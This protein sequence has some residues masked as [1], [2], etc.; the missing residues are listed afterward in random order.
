MPR[1]KQNGKP[2]GNPTVDQISKWL[3]LFI[4]PGQVTE[5]RALEVVSGKYKRTVSGYFDYEH[6]GTMAS[7]VLRLTGQSKGVYFVFNPIDSDCLSR[8]TNR[9][10][11][12]NKDEQ[13]SDNDVLQR[14]AILIDADPERKANISATDVEKKLAWETMKAIGQHLN[15]V[16]IN[17][18]VIADS[19][20]GYH[21][22]LW[23]NLPKEDAGM[24]K[25]FLHCLADQFGTDAV[26]I[27]TSVY[28]PARIT[29]LYGTMARK[30]DHSDERPHRWAYVLDDLGDQR[31]KAEAFA[32]YL[33]SKGWTLHD[34]EWKKTTDDP[35]VF[36]ATAKTNGRD[37]VSAARKYVSKL[38]DATSG[39][40]GHD[41]TWDVVHQLWQRFVPQGLSEPDAWDI[42]NEYNNTR[43]HPPWS[44]A[45]LAHKVEGAK[46]ARVRN[47]GKDF[48]P[49][50]DRKNVKGKGKKKKPQSIPQEGDGPLGYDIIKDWFETNFQPLHRTGT[51][52]FSA[53]LGRE[54]KATEATYA[55][56]IDLAKKLIE[57]AV[58]AKREGVTWNEATKFFSTWA[59]PAL[60]DLLAVLPEEECAD[61]VDEMAE[62]DFRDLVSM[63]LHTI[64]S[65][66]HKYQDGDQRTETQQRS[67]IEWAALFAKKGAFK[68]VR[69][70]EIWCKKDEDGSKQ[71]AIRHELFGQLRRADLRKIRRKKFAALCSRYGVGQ[72]DKINNSIRAIILTSEYLRDVCGVV[73]HEKPRA[74]A[75]EKKR[76]N[77]TFDANPTDGGT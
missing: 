33:E 72:S 49:E 21:R 74:H 30:G 11:F 41:A 16:G 10:D 15:E 34:E 3:K 37:I 24:V 28:N 50:P 38:P 47:L 48:V 43:C 9:T 68:K 46:N 73:A 56:S 19:G 64:I 23:V 7:E 71:I 75:S 25:A 14:S 76:H 45:E 39:N 61:E 29:K 55:P 17:G 59:K 35:S 65:L 5:L 12:A 42:L 40:H 62:E 52:F 13:T 54:V 27:D 18:G 26:S 51:G 77:A 1:T 57:E 4:Q 69:S 2:S 36:Q 66:G 67:L 6:L 8:R 32:A 70:Y 58:D 22:Y 60:R 20:N 53:T 44:Q 31:H 63:A